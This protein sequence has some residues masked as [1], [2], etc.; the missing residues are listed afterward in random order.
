MAGKGIA[1]FTDEMIDPRLARRLRAEGYDIESCRQ[2]GRSSRGIP[3][4]QQL[5]YAS[6]QG[7]VVLTFD[8]TDFEL[9]HA[10]WRAN[11]RRHGGIIVSAQVIDLEELIRRVRMH[12]DTVDPIDQAD[13]L[14][15]LVR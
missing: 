11:G 15:E 12:L 10:E 3:D 2:A 7:R 1:L 9:L 6:R 4:E 13:A 5:E 14:R 8:S